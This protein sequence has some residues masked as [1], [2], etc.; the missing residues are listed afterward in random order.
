M[1]A[2]YENV[3]NTVGSSS[4]KAYVEVKKQLIIVGFT[5]RLN[6]A[7]DKRCIPLDHA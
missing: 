3:I 1:C 2:L 7:S 6:E 5:V 4:S